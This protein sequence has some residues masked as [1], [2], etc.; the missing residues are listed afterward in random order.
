MNLGAAMGG[1]GSFAKKHKKKLLL[2]GAGGGI[3]AAILSGLMLLLPMRMEFVIKNLSQKF[4][5]LPE[6]AIEYRV[7]KLASKYFSKKMLQA[8]TGKNVFVGNNLAS[9]LYRNWQA[10]NFEGQLRER[11]GIEFDYNRRTGVHTI[12]RGNFTEEIKDSDVEKFDI[13]KMKSSDMRREIK[14][15]VK[16]ETRWNQVYK[17]RTLRR[18]LMN[19]YSVRKWSIL[20]DK[21]EQIKQSR[22]EL[23]RKFYREMIERV[24][25]PVSAKYASIFSCIV[26]GDAAGCADA[27]SPDVDGEGNVLNKEG[28]VDVDRTRDSTNQ[29]KA[30]LSEEQKEAFGKEDTHSAGGRQG[31]ADDAAE[32]VAEELIDKSDNLVGSKIIEVL[33]R[34]VVKKVIAAVAT[35]IGILEI[36]S[37]I[38]EAL[39]EGSVSEIITAKNSTQYANYFAT[40]AAGGDQFK[41]GE[42]SGEGVNLLMGQLNGMEESLVFQK[43]FIAS[44]PGGI[45][46]AAEPKDCGG[47]PL[48]A[49]ELVCPDKKVSQN[50]GPDEFYQ[51]PMFAPLKAILDAY[52]ASVGKVLGFLFKTVGAL[53]D[54]TIGP[55]LNE[56]MEW[57]GISEW[58]AKGFDKVMGF[59][60]G[61]VVSGTETGADAFD[62]VYAGAD[63]S[64]SALSQAIGGK[65]VTPKEAV[66]YSE[67]LKS[68]SRQEWRQKSLVA[69]LFSP[70]NPDSITTRLV[71]TT[72]TS[73]Q[74]ATGMIARIT[75]TWRY[76][77]RLLAGIFIPPTLADTA[78]FSP[79]NVITYA[80]PRNDPSRDLDPDQFTD[81]FCAQK[82]K[83]WAESKQRVASISKS[84]D[85]HTKTNPCALERVGVA[86]AGA[87]FTDDPNDGGLGIAPSGGTDESAPI[88]GLAY[89][90]NLGS[91]NGN[92]YY[93]MPDPQNKEYEFNLGAPPSQ[94]CGSKELVGLIYTLAVQWKQKY[95]DSLLQVW[96]LNA[97]G[98]A[99]HT[100]GIDVDLST[101]NDSGA[102]VAGSDERSIQ[103]GKWAVDTGIVELI[104]Y[105]DTAV[106]REVNRY[107]GREVMQYWAGHEDHFHVR[108]QSKFA[109]PESTSC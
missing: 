107:A 78:M 59:F 65:A 96:D 6:D 66:A 92:G 35:G 30:S 105:N 44:S 32:E 23:K 5:A 38:D 12:R 108:I 10:A 84:F 11:Q 54:D 62:A 43:E 109:G 36:I 19:K 4:L 21:R 25:N 53:V 82:D 26:D 88:K 75:A 69:R 106:I 29:A 13:E 93:K 68:E 79:H 72:P 20:G 45:V 70:D 64:G 9:S 49:G 55:L 60:F 77:P 101:T 22:L 71:I 104:F 46:Y 74:G 73:V 85:V 16:K 80:T 57:T 98:H 97:T 40:F 63:V 33:Q 61:A 14:A 91:P 1:V 34:A 39:E 99:S 90:P 47:E 94:R 67:E 58:V 37:N 56:F 89:P 15:A 86:V 7:N 51:E 24:V 52:Q 41:Q 2:G 31:I 42:L 27:K 8:S 76:L 28:G 87:M 95:N 17:R 48:A 50:F 102:N 3:L 83:E 18:V 81:E 100:R 103:L